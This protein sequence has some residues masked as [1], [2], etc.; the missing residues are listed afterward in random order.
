M[1]VGQNQWDPIL[2]VGA[3]PILEPILVGIG[4]LTIRDFDPWPNVSL[5]SSSE[6]HEAEAPRSDGEDEEGPDNRGRP[7]EADRVG[8]PIQALRAIVLLVQIHPV[9]LLER[10]DVMFIR[11]F[12]L[13]VPL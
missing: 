3:P 1:A 5:D 7:R 8:V 11:L 10:K 6:Q 2:G 9:G 13:Y 12:L 4:M